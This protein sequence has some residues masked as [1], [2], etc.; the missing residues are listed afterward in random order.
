M[1]PEGQV[2]VP[3]PAGL[4][5]AD[6]R[7]EAHDGLPW[8]CRGP[9]AHHTPTGG[10][11]TLH[12]RDGQVP[13]EFWPAFPLRARLGGRAVVAGKRPSLPGKPLP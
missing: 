4:W 9:T 3:S 13:T 5:G 10:L 7:S 6:P 1:H 8:G 2:K 11:R 12:G